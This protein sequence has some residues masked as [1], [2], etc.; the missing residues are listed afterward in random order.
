MTLGYF[1]L[2]TPA[3]KCIRVTLGSVGALVSDIWRVGERES[4]GR[5]E[6]RRKGR[7]EG[8][9]ERERV[10]AQEV[11]LIANMYL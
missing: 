4:R 9:R 7:S 1:S 10:D 11:T 3:T 5:G 6:G 2:T 8:R